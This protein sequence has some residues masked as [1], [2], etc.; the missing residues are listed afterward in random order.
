MLSLL[1]D[2]IPKK[3]RMRKKSKSGEKK[4]K[5]NRE[6]EDEEEKIYATP[7]HVHGLTT[8][9]NTH[10]HTQQKAHDIVESN[11]PT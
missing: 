11:V 9:K 8:E 6:N 5:N 3:R 7:P 4:M 1:N 2:A 10:A